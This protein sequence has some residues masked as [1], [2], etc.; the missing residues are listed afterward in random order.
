MWRGF[1]GGVWLSRALCRIGRVGCE[2][3]G[4]GMGVG[5]VSAICNPTVVEVPS[6]S[7]R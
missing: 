5:D 2:V 4:E 1:L 3:G 6:H 7:G